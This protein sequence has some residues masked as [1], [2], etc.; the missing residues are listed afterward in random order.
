M[1]KD[2]FG[3]LVRSKIFERAGQEQGAGGASIWGF[4]EDLFMNLRPG[5]YQAS[6]NQ[7]A[8]PSTA[9]VSIVPVIED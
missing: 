6:G 2:T 5:T 7:T 3:L 1:R 9:L 4:A 8:T